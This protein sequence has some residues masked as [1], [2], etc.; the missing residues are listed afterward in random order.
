MKKRIFV[1]SAKQGG[2]KTTYAKYLQAFLGI[3]NTKIFKFAA[4]LY[5]LHD[6]CLPLL[7]QYGVRDASMEKD[8]ELLQVL[9]SEYGRKCLGENVWVNV[10]AREVHAYLMGGPRRFAIIDDCRFENE[11]N[12]FRD[13]AY[14]I[15][16]VAPES[17]R[18]ARCSYWRENTQHPSEIGLDE[19]ERQ[20]LFDVVLDTSG[21]GDKEKHKN[22][23]GAIEAMLKHFGLIDV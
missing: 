19:Y 5:A 3:D 15:R 13:I 1:F 18:R 9:G 20:M 6:R 7:K 22:I 23:E 21:A 12:E 8:G 2:G 16:L 4:P 10:T 11:F 14:M 17:V